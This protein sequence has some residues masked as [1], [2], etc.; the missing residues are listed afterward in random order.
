MEITTPN[1]NTSARNKYK[2]GAVRQRFALNSKCLGH[3]LIFLRNRGKRQSKPSRAPTRQIPAPLF[4]A[5]DLFSKL[6]I[7]LRLRI[8]DE[9]RPAARIVKLIW[10]KKF[11]ENQSGFSRTHNITSRARVPNLLHTC[12]ESREVALKWYQLSFGWYGGHQAREDIATPRNWAKDELFGFRG[13]AGIYFDWSRDFIYLQCT[14]CSDR[15]GGLTLPD[16][17]QVGPSESSFLIY[18]DPDFLGDVQL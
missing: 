18:T 9:A 7:E 5:F 15:V 6:P 17:E 13:P 1:L 2:P 3:R 16:G 11:H 12:S 4:P 10:S 14:G 8:W